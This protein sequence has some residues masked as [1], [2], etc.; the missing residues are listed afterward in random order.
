MPL[1][2]E[3]KTEAH[4][5]A[6]E[7]SAIARSGKVLAGSIVERRTRCGRPG[8]RCMADPPQPHGPYYQWTRKIRAKTIGRWIT[9][10]QRDDY[11]PWLDNSRRLRELVTRL[12]AL[13]EAALGEAALETDPRSPS[14]RA[15]RRGQPTSEPVSDV[16]QRA[17]HT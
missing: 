8:C 9:P 14:R 6:A 16:T 3:H 7:L 2:P 17:R 11:Q 13:G 10:E 5:I 12:E 4:R 15:A 1:N